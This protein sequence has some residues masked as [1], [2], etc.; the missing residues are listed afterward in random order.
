MSTVFRLATRCHRAPGATRGEKSAGRLSSSSV[1]I[2]AAF[3]PP[4]RCAQE[5]A[6]GPDA[7]ASG[8]PFGR[9][10]A[11]FTSCKTCPR[12]SSSSAYWPAIQP[13]SEKLSPFPCLIQGARSTIPASRGMDLHGDCHHGWSASSHWFLSAFRY[14]RCGCLWAVDGAFLTCSLPRR[15]RATLACAKGL[16]R[17]L[18]PI[19]ARRQ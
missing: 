15:D 10:P 12:K 17:T 6:E 11:T 4:C 7:G 8:A 14:V 9:R 5:A 19:A 2:R 18:V 1:H 3:N 16:P 13:S